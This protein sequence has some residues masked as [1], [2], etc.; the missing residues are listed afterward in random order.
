MDVSRE[1][2]GSPYDSVRF[3]A[4]GKPFFW[5]G[6]GSTDWPVHLAFVAETRAQV[7]AF[8]AAALE[9]VCH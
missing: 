8:R 9:A 2:T 5:I 6:E 3:G 7:D 1:E 4:A